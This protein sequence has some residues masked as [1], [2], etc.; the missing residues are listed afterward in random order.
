MAVRDRAD[1][2]GQ[3]ATRCYCHRNRCRPGGLGT[4]ISAVFTPGFP[5]VSSSS[6]CDGSCAASHRSR[7]R[8]VVMTEP[9]TERSRSFKD[10]R[11]SV[12][13]RPTLTRWL[14]PR[15]VFARCRWFEIRMRERT[16][17]GGSCDHAV[18]AAIRTIDIRCHT[19][20]SGSPD[21]RLCLFLW[22]WYTVGQAT[23]KI[24]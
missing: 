5:R 18:G 12:H 15:K 23:Q 10:G 21:N 19:T 20:A 17:N 16:G 2:G 1:D 13:H 22:A 3:R 7:P 11:R 6:A 4:A 24:P 8:I 14:P 9:T